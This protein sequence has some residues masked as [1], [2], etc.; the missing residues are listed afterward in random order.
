I[1][2]IGCLAIIFYHDFF[3]AENELA[4]FDEAKEILFANWY[5]FVIAIFTTFLVL[6]FKGA[7]LSV[8]C[9]VTTKKFHF[10]T[11]FETGIIGTYY[12]NVTPLA[13]GGQPFEIYHLTKHG[14]NGGAASSLPIVAFFLNQVAF[15]I[16]SIVSLALLK[17]NTFNAFT[18]TLPVIIKS[19]AIVGLILCMFVP[20]LV[21]IF[22]LTPRLCGFLVKFVIN[23]GG[24]LRIIK[25]PKA[26]TFNILKT[27]M[28]NSRC[29]K[30]IATSPIRFITSILLSFC[31]QLA[32]ASI[33]Y[34][35]L[36]F[37]GFDLPEGGFIEWLMVVQLCFILYS[38][39]SFIP[40]PGNSG[41][42]D[43]S[44]N[45][46]FAA[47]MTVG[48]RPISGLAFPALIVWRILSFYSFIIIGFI[49]IRK[50]NR[51]EKLKNIPPKQP[52][53]LDFD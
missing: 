52:S 14:V 6:F 34:F 44:F 37:F 2:V 39:V 49:F 24:K 48:S 9:H 35:V 13:V 50:R 26:T 7:K 30:K 19:L 25:N 40:T 43:I 31:E 3:G 11:C 21:F 22:S 20:S 47:G 46:L 38:A 18:S 8:L 12:N 53:L 32:N 42:A 17:K 23:L 10:K 28:L 45:T 33:A 1:L 4:S 5:Y 51:R 41:A 15:V 16:L 36:R 29:I 27:V